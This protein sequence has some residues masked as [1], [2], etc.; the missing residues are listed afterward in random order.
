MMHTIPH[1]AAGVMWTTLY[2]MR[3]RKWR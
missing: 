1:L 3:L 2:A